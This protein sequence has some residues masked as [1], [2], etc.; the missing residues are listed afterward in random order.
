VNAARLETS[1]CGLQEDSFTGFPLVQLGGWR[2][3]THFPLTADWPTV[4]VTR[5]MQ[6]ATTHTHTH[7]FNGPLSGTTHVSR[8]QKGKT[9]LLLI[10]LKHETVSGSGISWAICKSA[11]RSRQITTPALHHSVFCRP[12]A[13]PDTQATASEGH[14]TTAQRVQNCTHSNDTNT[15]SVNQSSLHSWHRLPSMTPTTTNV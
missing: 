14:K 9:N 15:V 11:P 8:Y 2:I 4:R 6:V 7:L 5:H 13:L 1:I 10:L 12:D 3:S